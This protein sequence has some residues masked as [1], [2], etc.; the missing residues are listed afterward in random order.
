MPGPSEYIR[1]PEQP[2]THRSQAVV[3]ASWIDGPEVKKSERTD[4]VIGRPLDER[5]HGP[6]RVEFFYIEEEVSERLLD[7]KVGSQ[8]HSCYV[9]DNVIFGI[10]ISEMFKQLL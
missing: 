4:H 6:V 9:V 8:K 5:T 3:S 7:I 10:F 2:L 1:W